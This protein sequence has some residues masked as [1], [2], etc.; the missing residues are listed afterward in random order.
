MSEQINNGSARGRGWFSSCLLSSFWLGV[1]SLTTSCFFVL[2]ALV[3]VSV[4]LNAYLGW[5]R[6]G[7]EVV[8][9]M[10]AAV[11]TATMTEEAIVVQPTSTPEIYPAIAYNEPNGYGTTDKYANLAPLRD[12]NAASHANPYS[13]HLI[14]S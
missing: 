13:H 5:A 6:S 10:P 8:V 9:N 2:C 14:I 1:L 4:A 3:M 12:P 11:P 7:V